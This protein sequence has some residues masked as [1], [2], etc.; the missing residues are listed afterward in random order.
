[1]FFR[2][3]SSS[4]GERI[5]ERQSLSADKWLHRG[6]GRIALRRIPGLLRGSVLVAVYRIHVSNDMFR[7][8]HQV[9]HPPSPQR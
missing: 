6:G 8:L 7:A 5:D 9:L 3:A 1:M 2:L 4:R